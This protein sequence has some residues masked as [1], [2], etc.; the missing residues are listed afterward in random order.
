MG[1]EKLNLIGKQDEHLELLSEFVMIFIKFL[2]SHFVF[3]FFRN[4]LQAV[5]GKQT[6]GKKDKKKSK[7][8]TQLK[9][10]SIRTLVSLA[11]K[12]IL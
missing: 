7:D 12:I 9:P 5:D 11:S 2:K 1:K 4:D 3:I 8:E 10:V 6:K